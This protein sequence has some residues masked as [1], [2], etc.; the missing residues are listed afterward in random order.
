MGISEEIYEMTN[1]LLTT[2]SSKKALLFDLF[3]TLTPL[4]PTWKTAPSTS[5]MLGVSREDW[6]RQ[7]LEC[8]RE[9]LVG[10]MTDPLKIIRDLAH[11]I[12]PTISEDTI[13][14]TT[15]NRINQFA[16]SLINIPQVNVDVLTELK[17]S[18][19]K[20]ALIS[21]ADV[22]EAQGWGQSPIAKLFHE[23]LF[24][25]H[26]G[27]AKPEPEIYNLCMQQLGLA[28]DECIF[29]GDGGSNEHEGARACGI[30][31]VM[32]TG[33]IKELWPNKVEGR[34]TQADYVIENLSELLDSEM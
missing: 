34:M 27:W 17:R 31:T 1:N 21:N 30:T 3:H 15:E 24:S 23:T 2:I 7:L 25:C 4:E 20:L 6:N 10:K 11:A 33:I 14:R 32:V 29:V 22:M 19:K 28:P 5:G 26:V 12:D 18:G 16:K 9:R 13:V 8:S